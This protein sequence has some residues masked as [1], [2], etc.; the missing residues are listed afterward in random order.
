MR[1]PCVI[2]KGPPIIPAFS[3]LSSDY[4]SRIAYF[5]R[6]G[7]GRF[8]RV[9]RACSRPAVTADAIDL[10]R[11]VEDRLRAHLDDA[12]R[13]AVDVQDDEHEEHDER[14][15]DESRARGSV[16]REA[17][18]VADDANVV[19]IAS[20]CDFTAALVRAPDRPPRR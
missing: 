11:H 7:A 20:I 3:I 8:I 18:G 10:R 17:R 14:H 19:C 4:L 2:V 9:S 6:P 16:T 12:A 15:H 13:R 5:L 1:A